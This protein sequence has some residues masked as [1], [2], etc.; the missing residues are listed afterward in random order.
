MAKSNEKNAYTRIV[1]HAWKDARFKEKLLKNP[2]EALKE[3]GMDVPANFDVRVI[4]EKTNTMTFILPKAPAQTR[5]LSEQEL[6]KLAGGAAL[7]APPACPSTDCEPMVSLPGC[8]GPESP[9]PK[10]GRG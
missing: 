2:K 6:Q 7:S 8:V 4:E 9:S 1:A 10:R 3:M 5:E